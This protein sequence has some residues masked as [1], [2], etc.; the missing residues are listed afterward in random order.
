[1]SDATKRVLF[2]LGAIIETFDAFTG[3]QASYTRLFDNQSFKKFASIAAG[4]TVSMP[5]QQRLRRFLQRHSLE[6]FRVISRFDRG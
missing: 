5:R 4:A 3:R 1:M 6:M 2:Q